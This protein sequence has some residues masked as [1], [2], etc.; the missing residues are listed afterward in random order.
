M[1]S[2]LTK[3]MR[4]RLIFVII[5]CLVLLTGYVSAVLF[6]AAIINHKE[7]TAMANEQQQQSTSIKSNR[8]TIYDR[9][10]K[11]LAQST[12]TWDVIISPY[13]INE[14]EPENM[15]FICRGLAD[16]LDVSYSDL[17]EACKDTESPYHRVKRDVDRT[18]ITIMTI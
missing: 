2:K 7:M 15:E 6:N 16:I 14:N 9:N 17:I 18:V 8:G 4:T 13:D 11:V 1:D 12:T 10:N 3:G 5:F